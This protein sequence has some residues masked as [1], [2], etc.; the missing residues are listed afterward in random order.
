MG[1]PE[2]PRPAPPPSAPVGGAPEPAASPPVLKKVTPEIQALINTA[3]GGEAARIYANGFTLGMT[4]ADVFVVLQQFGR[5]IAVVNVSYT[6]AKTLSQKLR[7]L[8]DDWEKKTGQTLQTTD[9]ID[10]KFKDVMK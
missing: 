1:G 5:P 6:L 10:T 7:D 9:S 4:N 2:K 3:L 8:V